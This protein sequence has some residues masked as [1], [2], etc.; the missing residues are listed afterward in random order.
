MEKNFLIDSE[1]KNDH[2]K[3]ALKYESPYNSFDEIELIHT[4]IPKYNLNEIDLS[5]KF[6]GYKFEYPFFINAIT[7]GSEKGREINR[8]LA[9][10]ANETGI[11]FVTGSYSAK[12]KNPKDDSFEIVKREN[13]NLLLGT[14]IGIDKGYEA[15]IKAVEDLQPLFLQIHVNLMQELIMPEGSRNFSEWEI[16]LKNYVEKI[17]KERKIPLILKEVGFGMD[18]KTIQKATNI[19]VKTFDI[20][21]RGGTS[22]SYIENMRNVR[23][24]RFDYLNTWGQSTVVSLLEVQKYMD[25]VEIIS[26]GGVRNPL[27]IIKSLVLG[28]KAVGLSRTMLEL[29]G[30]YDV[31]KVIEIINEWKYELKMI[32]CALNCKRISDLQKVRYILYGK[33]KDYVEQL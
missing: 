4:S 12:L 1:R 16:N 31:N 30:K 20:S 21:G 14:N 6:A 27:D 28:A 22:F 5:T 17:Q 10:I 7:G 29:V 26:S 9:K 33:V 11:L 3:Y 15:G 8:K 13:K 23:K 19:G 32:M 2:I 25:K 24:G 18:A